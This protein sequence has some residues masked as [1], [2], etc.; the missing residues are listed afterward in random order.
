MQKDGEGPCDILQPGWHGQLIVIDTEESR[1]RSSIQTAGGG[2]GG[3]RGEGG[4]GRRGG[5]SVEGEGRG[6]GSQRTGSNGRRLSRG[7][8]SPESWQRRSRRRPPSPVRQRA[9]RRGALRGRGACPRALSFCGSGSR[10]AVAIAPSPSPPARARAKPVRVHNQRRRRGTTYPGFAVN[11]DGA[12]LRTEAFGQ[13]DNLQD[14]LLRGATFRHDVGD[15][16][17]QLVGDVV[18]AGR[19]L[20]LRVSDGDEAG[21]SGAA[22]RRDEDV[23]CLKLLAT[24]I[25]SSDT[26]I[27]DIKW[28]CPSSRHC[29][30]RSCT[31][32]VN[33]SHR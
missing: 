7:V 17:T 2:G 5:R 9:L 11:E 22:L 12:G 29:D 27:A 25:V 13:P 1:P 16:Q 6:L 8:S 20:V 26:S 32:M 19:Q 4:R 3:G 18:V 30:W 21:Y 33:H 28:S 23:A 24:S 15:E 10:P 14:V 31:G